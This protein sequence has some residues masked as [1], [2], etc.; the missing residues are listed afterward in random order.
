MKREEL[1]KQCRFYKGEKKNPY[2]GLDVRGTIWEGEGRWVERLLE[3]K[4]AFK[5][6]R[7]YTKKTDLYIS[8]KTR[9]RRCLVR[10]TFIPA[11]VI[12][13]D[14]VSRREMPLISEIGIIKYINKKAAT[15][16]KAQGLG[17]LN[18]AT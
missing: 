8:V 4:N 10:V 3:D 6:T 17:L 12:G 16:S 7:K 1:I 13:A 18:Q 9:T 2:E 14:A 5:S 15:D 11:S